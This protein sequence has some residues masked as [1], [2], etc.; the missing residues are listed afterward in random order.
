[1][2]DTQPPPPDSETPTNYRSQRLTLSLLLVS[3]VLLLTSVVATFKI[4]QE[5]NH[6]DHELYH[7]KEDLQG[8]THEM[9]KMEKQLT[10]TPTTG[11]PK[12]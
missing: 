11:K 9:E 3:T 4:G 1:M 12:R 2:S 8:M 10:E 5:A 6:Y 7:L